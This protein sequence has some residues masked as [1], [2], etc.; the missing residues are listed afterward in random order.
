MIAMDA[1]CE[2]CAP[3]KSFEIEI[4]TNDLLD[5]LADVLR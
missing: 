4:D 1:D 5:I 3:L 2:G